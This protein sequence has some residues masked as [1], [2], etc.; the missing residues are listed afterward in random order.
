MTRYVVAAFSVASLTFPTLLL[1]DIPLKATR[2]ISG[3]SKPLFV[4]SAPGDPNRLYVVEQ[5]GI[6][7][8]SSSGVIRIYDYG[9]GSLSATPFLTIPNLATGNEQGL[10]GLAFHP[11]YATNG[12]L[13][14]DVTVTGTGQ[15]Q[16]RQYTR[17]NANAADPSSA[18]TLMSR[19]QPQ[20][21]HN[22]G[23]LGFGPNDGYLYVGAG[24]GGNANDMG[25]GHTEPGGNAQDITS[26][27]LG[28]ML[29]STSTLTIS[30]PMP[31]KTTRFPPAIP[32]PAPPRAM[33]KSGITACEIP[34][35]PASTAPPAIST[36]PT[37]VRM[38]ERKSISSRMGSAG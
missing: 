19:N 15:T 24:D 23:W 29:A 2:I 36:S 11:D 10:L 21:N 32:S 16:I 4:T 5:T 12:K 13:Y 22:G 20:S 35:G 31:P 9:T 1:A 7:S 6:G 17:L 34:G 14:V 27:H 28:K 26:N 18:T 25:T 37:S 33:T 38:P 30:P 8:L 3:V